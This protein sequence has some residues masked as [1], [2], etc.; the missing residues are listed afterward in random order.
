MALNKAG[1]HFRTTDEDT[2]S[3]VQRLAVLYDDTT[4]AL[5]LSR[6]P[7]HHRYRAAVHQ[8]AGQVPPRLSRHPRPRA[9]GCRTRG[10]R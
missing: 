7:A 6:Q 1:G 4:I 3:L 5:I 9:S 2:V 10:R 8:S